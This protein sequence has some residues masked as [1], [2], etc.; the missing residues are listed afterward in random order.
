MS[1]KAS[2][3]EPLWDQNVEIDWRVIQYL[4]CGPFVTPILDW[5]YFAEARSESSLELAGQQASCMRFSPK[6]RAGVGNL[7]WSVEMDLTTE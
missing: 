3:L 1:W 4:S 2:G 6:A 7:R 5:L